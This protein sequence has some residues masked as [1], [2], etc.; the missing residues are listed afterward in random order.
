M[1]NVTALVA[2]VLLLGVAHA[3][4]IA[5]V[6]LK[7]EGHRRQALTIGPDG[8]LWATEVLKHELLRITPTG[9]ITEFPVSGKGVGVLQGIAGG[10]D[11]NIWFTS[12]E[13]NSIR[14]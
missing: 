10:P 9:E 3:G 1:K 2:M 11:G 13:E 7:S 5:E 14:R 8:N 6:A 12:R 4:E